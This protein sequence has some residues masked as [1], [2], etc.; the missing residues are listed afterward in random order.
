MYLQR[1]LPVY[2]SYC[3]LSGVPQ[4]SILG[5]Y[6]RSITGQCLRRWPVID[7]AFGQRIM[8]MTAATH[9]ARFDSLPHT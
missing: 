6:A 4:G 8:L 7:S 5:H 9:G 1:I 3:Q 2:N